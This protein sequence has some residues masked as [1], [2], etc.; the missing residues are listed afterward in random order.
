MNKIDK[1]GITLVLLSAC[2]FI[3]ALVFGLDEI[4]ALKVCTIGAIAGLLLMAIPNIWKKEK[5]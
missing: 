4:I 2:G 5:S 3:V 1:L